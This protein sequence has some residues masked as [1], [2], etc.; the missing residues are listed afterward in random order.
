MEQRTLTDADV[1][2]IACAVNKQSACSLGI[3]ADDAS[4]LCEFA[5]WLRKLKNAIGNVVIYG[6]IM[7]LAVLFYLGVGKWK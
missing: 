4:E 3:S 6:F 1:E 7:F 2:A 5:A